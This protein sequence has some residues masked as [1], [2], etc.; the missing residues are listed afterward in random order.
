MIR[1]GMKEAKREISNPRNHENM[2]PLN[3]SHIGRSVTIT[4]VNGRIESGILKAVGAYMI[5][6]NGANGRDLIINKG[7]IITVSVI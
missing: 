2:E 5:S 4:M 3:T 6:I 7:A 1:D